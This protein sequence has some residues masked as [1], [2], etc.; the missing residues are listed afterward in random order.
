M[1]LYS[2]PC[3]SAAAGD[4]MPDVVHVRALMNGAEGRWSVTFTV[5]GSTASISLSGYG[6]R[7]GTRTPGSL[8][9]SRFHLTA[10]ASNG[11]PSWKVMPVRSL[12]VY[13]VP[14]GET[15]QL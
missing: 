15:V 3:L 8:R 4:T 5:V 11:V 10:F 13:W 6:A 2:L 12:N 1:L 7:I 9:R 14:S